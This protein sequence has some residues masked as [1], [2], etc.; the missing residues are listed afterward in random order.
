MAEDQH[1]RNGLTVHAGRIT[2]PAVAAA[3][4]EKLLRAEEAIVP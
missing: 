3:L 2:H 4:G 1:L